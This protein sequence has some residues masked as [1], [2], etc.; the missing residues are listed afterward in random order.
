MNPSA[1][2]TTAFDAVVI[3]AGAG[4]LAA[5]AHLVAAGRKVLVAERLGRRL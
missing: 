5:A 1:P 4:G 3:G 2:T